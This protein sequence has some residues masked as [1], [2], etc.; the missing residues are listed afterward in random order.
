MSNRKIVI[1]P[2]SAMKPIVMTDSDDTPIEEI[3]N[4]IL[5]IFQDNKVSIFETENDCLITKPCEIQAILIT[6][7]EN[8]SQSEK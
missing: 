2:K 5:N 6:K 3:K 7:K 1:Y 8:E 4:K